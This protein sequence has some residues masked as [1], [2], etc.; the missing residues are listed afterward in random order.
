MESKLEPMLANWTAGCRDSRMSQFPPPLPPS[1][2]RTP[3]RTGFA[4]GLV[5][6]LAV[7]LAGSLMLN[8]GLMGRVREKMHRIKKAE[9]PADQHPSLK[10]VWSYGYGQVKVARIL[11]SGLIFR[12]EEDGLFAQPLNIVDSVLAQIRCAQADSEVRGIIFEVDSP[13]GGITAS[14][15]LYRALLE[16]RSSD[17]G[18][19]V[20]VFMR[21][22][23]AS[24]GYYVSLGGD[25]LIAQPTTV[26]GSIGVIMQTLNIKG[27]SEKI[28]VKDVTIKSGPNKDLLNPFNE[29]DPAQRAL[30]QE[31]ID[32]LYEHFLGIVASNRPAISPDR[33][34]GLADGRLFVARQALEEGLIDQIGHWPDAMAKMSEL[35][36]VEGIKVIRYEQTPDFW[37]WLLS[38]RAPSPATWLSYQTRPR[39]LYLWSP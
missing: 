4:W 21:D 12:E 13:G 32:E 28:G 22:L 5:V 38:V 37:R 9:Q 27:L 8:A 16:F 29:V 6:I 20:V 24:G 15:E 26:L 19:F 34:R 10:E 30:V 35:L 31:M 25:W 18:R 1:K 11:L 17:T 39:F 7:L 36:G 14:D 23:A 33:L 2:R 3:C